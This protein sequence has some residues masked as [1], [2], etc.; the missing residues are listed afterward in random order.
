[1]QYNIRTRNLALIHYCYICCK[2]YS[3]FTVLKSASVSMFVCW[4]HATLS[5]VQLCVSNTTIKIQRCSI[6]IKELSLVLFY[7]HSA[8]T[9]LHAHPCPLTTTKLFFII[10]SFVILEFNINGTI[11]YVIW[12]GLNFFIKHNTLQVH[13]GCGIYQQVIPYQGCIVFYGMDINKVC[14]TICLLNSI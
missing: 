1:M 2:L 9:T 10:L 7:S 4:F 12:G 5:H 14:S 6:T 13:I 3:A 11:K 8:P